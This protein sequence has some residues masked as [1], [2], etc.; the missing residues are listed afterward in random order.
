MVGLVRTA[1]EWSAAVL[2]GWLL[3]EVKEEKEVKAG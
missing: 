2:G 3:L 1:E